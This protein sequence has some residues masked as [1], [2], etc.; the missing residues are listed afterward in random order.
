MAARPPLYFS[1]REPRS[2]A[3]QRGLRLLQ[4]ATQGSAWTS[5]SAISIG[6]NATVTQANA[7]VGGEAVQCRGPN[8][9]TYTVGAIQQPMRWTCYFT[10]SALTSSA[11][12]LSVTS[13]G[14]GVTTASTG[15]Q[16][17][18]TCGAAGYYDTAV[19]VWDEVPYTLV[20]GTVNRCV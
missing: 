19:G 18:I 16:S 13:G 11:Y 9:P 6:A 1:R 15:T 2:P 8:L 17:G 3:S 4:P 10:S 20:S 7:Y 12:G 5:A 14:S